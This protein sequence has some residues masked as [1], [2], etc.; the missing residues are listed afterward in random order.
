MI[1]A[2]DKAEFKIASDFADGLN[3]KALKIYYSDFATLRP[4]ILCPVK[5]PVNAL[6]PGRSVCGSPD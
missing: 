6:H 1:P 5:W 4:S 3:L 2:E